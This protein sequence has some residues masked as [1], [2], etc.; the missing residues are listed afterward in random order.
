[1]RMAL[2][3]CVRETLAV[4]SCVLLEVERKLLTNKFLLA[5]I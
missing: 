2:W 5:L 4:M 3:H 1:M